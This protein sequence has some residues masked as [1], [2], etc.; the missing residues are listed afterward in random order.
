VGAIKVVEGLIWSGYDS[1]CE[2]SVP[3]STGLVES[4]RLEGAPIGA[5]CSIDQGSPPKRFATLPSLSDAKVANLGAAEGW[6]T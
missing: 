6:F 3:N 1:I 5:A 2:K 4:L